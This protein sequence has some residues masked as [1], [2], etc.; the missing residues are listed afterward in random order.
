MYLLYFEDMLELEE[1][2][3]EGTIP[4]EINRLGGLCEFVGHVVPL[5]FLLSQV[6][7]MNIL[8]VCIPVSQLCCFS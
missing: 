8:L 5:S 3:L 2:Q 4:T 6:P 1:N 7:L